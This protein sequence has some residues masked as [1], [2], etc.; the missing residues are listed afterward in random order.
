MSHFGSIDVKF[1]WN[2]NLPPPELFKNNDAMFKNKV[3]TPEGGILFSFSIHWCCDT[4]NWLGGEAGP[5]SCNS[6][7]K[8]RS[9]SKYTPLVKLPT[10]IHEFF[11]HYKICS[12]HNEKKVMAFS[13][14]L[15]CSKNFICSYLKYF[16][17]FLD[18]KSSV[19]VL[20]ASIF[21]L[22]DKIRKL[23]SNSEIR[24]VNLQFVGNYEAIEAIR[25]L[26]LTRCKPLR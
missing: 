10:V 2:F 8:I 4:Y 3:T 23:C 19:K 12:D 16:L 13:E 5:I 1:C 11:R 6:Y 21:M 17:R 18:E 24:W 7:L 15:Y 14:R 20:E 26:E 25:S 9:Y 22:F